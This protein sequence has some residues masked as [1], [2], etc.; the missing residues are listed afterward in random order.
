MTTLTRFLGKPFFLGKPCAWSQATNLSNDTGPLVPNDPYLLNFKKES[1]KKESL[2]KESLKKDSLAT[3]QREP[4]MLS[5]VLIGMNLQ[6]NV[7]KSRTCPKIA[8]PNRRQAL[9]LPA[10]AGIGAAFSTP[11]NASDSKDSVE[12]RL[13]GRQVRRPW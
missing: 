12:L 4:S 6:L 13:P 8:R 5:A 7:G 9:L 11:T 10:S 3:I 2:K 1:L